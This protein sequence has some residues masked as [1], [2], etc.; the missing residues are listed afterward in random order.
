[1][2]GATTVKGVRGG[3][4][5]EDRESKRGVTRLD[6]ADAYQLVGVIKWVE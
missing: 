1:M 6:R 3:K 4:Q 5:S 2:S